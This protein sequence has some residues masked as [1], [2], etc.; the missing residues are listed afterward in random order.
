MSS[1]NTETNTNPTEGNGEQNRARGNQHYGGRG[2]QGRGTNGGRGRGRDSRRD[3]RNRNNNNRRQ[4]QRFRGATD[5]IEDYTFGIHEGHTGAKKYTDNLKQLKIYAYRHCTTD[6][7]SLF[8]KNP[9]TP[10]VK[11]PTPLTELQ[12]KDE[13]EKELYKLALREYVEQSRKMKQEVKKIYGVILGQCTEA[14]VNKL[15]ALDNF[16]DFNDKADSAELLTEIRKITYLTDDKEDPFMSAAKTSNKLHRLVQDRESLTDYY[17]TWSNMAEVV[18]QKGGGFI[19]DEL[20]K[21]VLKE[22]GTLQ[23]A[24]IMKKIDDEKYLDEN[25]FKLYRKARTRAEDR[26][27]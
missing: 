25:E 4:T 10:E 21:V 2:H 5:E 1:P 11:K 17:S 3:N 6:V 23:G 26:F 8:G 9:K 24:S 13:T 22:G 27:L 20:I 15:K 12:K 18:K 19:N 7:G 16:D 14:M